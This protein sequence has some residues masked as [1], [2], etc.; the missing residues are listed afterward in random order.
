LTP[1]DPGSYQSA[2]ST[3]STCNSYPILKHAWIN[4]QNT[5]ARPLNLLSDQPYRP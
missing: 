4:S 5:S 2:T 1:E 3:E